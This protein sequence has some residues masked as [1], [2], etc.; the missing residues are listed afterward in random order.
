MCLLFTTADRQLSS[1]V[2]ENPNLGSRRPESLSSGKR[3]G[4]RKRFWRSEKR[5][6][7]SSENVLQE[8]ASPEKMGLQGNGPPGETGVRG[9]LP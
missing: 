6:E 3:F 7:K 2:D 1:D 8:R 5:S 9:W 4:N